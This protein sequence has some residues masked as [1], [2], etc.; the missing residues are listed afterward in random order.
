MGYRLSQREEGVIRLRG[1]WQQVG[2]QQLSAFS[3]DGPHG[4]TDRPA[5]ARGRLD[6][7]GLLLE[8]GRP[9]AWGRETWGV[10]WR[11]RA[12]TKGGC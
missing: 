11:S 10:G 3:M 7:A 6:V 2:E 4:A 5:L 8:S 12:W 9:P 1:G